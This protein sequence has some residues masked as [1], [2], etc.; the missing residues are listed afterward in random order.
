MNAIMFKPNFQTHMLPP[1]TGRLTDWDL[2]TV[3]QTK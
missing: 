1:K 3:A 2:M